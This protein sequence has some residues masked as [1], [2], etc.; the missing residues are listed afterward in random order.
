MVQNRN[1]Q[2][3]SQLVEK[4]RPKYQ[5]RPEPS[6]EQWC[7]RIKRKS[8]SLMLDTG[9]FALHNRFSV[10]STKPKWVQYDASQTRQR[11]I[12]V[13]AYKHRSHKEKGTAFCRSQPASSPKVREHSIIPPASAVWKKEHPASEPVP[14]PEPTRTSEPLSSSSSVIEHSPGSQCEQLISL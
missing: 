8:R 14:S 3:P 5:D 12:K 9:G 4:P 6:D 7:Q 13:R 1:Q 10:L 2:Q 11:R